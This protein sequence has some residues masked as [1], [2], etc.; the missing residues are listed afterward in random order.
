MTADAASNVLLLPGWLNSGPAHW[1]SRWEHL[2]GY[3]R[4]EQDDWNWPRRGD[5][6]ARLEEVVLAR[7]APVV[8][9][10]HSLGCHLVAAW[11]AHTSCADRV[12]ATLLVAPPDPERDDMPPHLYAWRP[13]VRTRLPFRS[14]V[15]ISEDDPYCAPVRAAQWAADWGAEVRQAGALGHINGDSGLGDWPQ[16]HAWLTELTALP[17]R[18]QSAAW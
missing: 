16:G 10:A 7:D 13:I 11:A 2:H 5:W 4:V 9:V 15:V 1:Q 12:M 6:S 18:R 17:D 8:L 3:R 14:V